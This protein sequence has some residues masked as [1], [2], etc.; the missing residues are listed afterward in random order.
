MQTQTANIES[1]H[2]QVDEKINSNDILPTQ[3]D[4]E[5]EQFESKLETDR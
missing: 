1:A 3:S 4:D 5:L 2:S